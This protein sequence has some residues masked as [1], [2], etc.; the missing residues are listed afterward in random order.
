MCILAPKMVACGRH[1]NITLMA[2]SELVDLKGKAG[3]FIATI[4][5]KPRYVDDSKCTGCGQC[6]AL[7]PIEVPNE[8]DS[9]L[10]LRKAI[11]LPF[12][13]AFPNTY[14]IDLE[15]CIECRTCER[16]CRVKAISFDQSEKLEEIRIGSIVLAAGFKLWDPSPLRE[17][18]YRTHPNVITSLQF[19]RLMNAAGPTGG[20]ILR[21]SDGSAP[22][23][24]AFIQC[25]GS[26]SVNCGVPYCSSFCCM[27]ATKEAIM[28]KEHDTTIEPY[29]FYSELRAARK[30]FQEY[31]NRAEE[32][33]VKY[34]KGIPSEIK[35]NRQTESLELWYED[36]NE[37]KIKA[38][39][40]DLTVLCP[41][42]IP[43]P[44]IAK[45]QEIMNF[46]IDDYGFVKSLRNSIDTTREGIFVC[47][48][49]E[50]PKDIPDSIA[51]A[52]GAAAASTLYSE[53][54]GL[55][56]EEDLKSIE[57]ADVRTGVFVCHCGTNIGGTI[58]VP[59][60]TAQIRNQPTVVHAEEFMFACSEDALI[61]LK[62]AIKEYG[63]NRVVVASCT[64]RTHEP[65]FRSACIEAG[66]NPYLF[67]MANIRDQCSWVHQGE[68][69]AATEKAKDLVRMAIAKAKFAEPLKRGTLNVEKSSLIIGGGISGITA[70][71]SL[72]EQGFKVH[73]IE[74]EN[75]LGGLLRDHHRLLPDFQDASE[76]LKE[77]TN[78]IKK[79]KN[80]K[81]YTSSS[82]EDVKGYVGNFEVSI[83]QEGIQKALKVGTIIV[84]TGA[85]P[86]EPNGLYEYGKNEN[87]ITQSDLE[88]RINR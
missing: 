63:L 67:V 70:S 76:M 66:L 45:L 53:I 54:S 72:A 78:S 4:M 39:E 2:Y 9:D 5:R 26:R 34:I 15:N 10:S 23:K 52:S 35:S 43:H 69:E 19:E 74:K 46:D 59:D 36:T 42:I 31:V 14:T 57:E 24:I 68:P 40:V 8:F 49:A 29:I 65:L 3:E 79:H 12:P 50:G 83:N 20:T 88:L 86:L 21:P 60:V 44:D 75:E 81:V 80:I 6:T 71:L 56:F 73:L 25:V 11:Y 85:N 61:K 51:Q 16:A 48:V 87:I 17:Y 18:G 62:D 41:A 82:L 38:L 77:I 27:Y 33:G 7:C 55:T 13:Q 28:A 37:R 47:G 84:A 32:E 30:G 22:K 58:D 64:P 1:P